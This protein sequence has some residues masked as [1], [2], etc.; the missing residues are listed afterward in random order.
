MVSH[1]SR[2]QWQV[3]LK[4]DVYIYASKSPCLFL[5]LHHHLCIVGTLDSLMCPDVFAVWLLHLLEFSFYAQRML[6]QKSV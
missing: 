6:C 3:P 4:G 5:P 1:K 2:M